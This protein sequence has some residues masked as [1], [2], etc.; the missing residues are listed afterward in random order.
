MV[1]AGWVAATFIAVG[2][3]VGRLP[4]SGGARTA[5]VVMTAVALVLWLVSL[6]LRV[7]DPR[8]L[9]ACLLGA[10]LLGAAIDRVNPRGPAYILA[11]MAVAGLGLRLPRRMAFVAGAAVVAAVA[12]AEG[13]TSDQPVPAAVNIAIGAGFLLVA[14]AFAGANRDAND[15]AQELLRLQ[16]ETRQAREEAA[17]LAERGRIARELHD[18]LAH[19]LSGLAV[20]LEGARL[21]AAH[22]GADPRLVEQVTNAQGLARSGMT[23]AKRAV[24]T[25]RGDELPGP[26]QVPELVQQAR[27]ATGAPV[28]LTVVGEPTPLPAE[29]GLPLY[30]AV[31]EALANVAKHA[32]GAAATVTLTWRPDSV[33]VEV[34]DT[35]GR[36]AGL[37]SGGFGLTG[38]AER[39]A[40]A[41][42]RLDSGPTHGGW[43]VHLT[44]PLD[45][46]ASR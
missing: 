41:G 19:T 22:T 26:A 42:G 40:H 17:V 46:E 13:S 35:G 6:S 5:V 2:T 7:T 8:V 24:A 14:A 29:R 30:R 38:L 11:F 21:L 34:V 3:A 9:L 44:M 31:Q 18:V 10:G 45:Q 27:L 43:R 20:Q 12:W 36:S 33:E 1:V 16:D 28:T 32:Q 15:R 23:G 39:A 4:S 25:L 37:P